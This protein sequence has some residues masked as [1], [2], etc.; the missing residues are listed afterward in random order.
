MNLPDISTPARPS[1]YAI[2]QR[3]ECPRKGWLIA[4]NTSPPSLPLLARFQDGHLV[5]DAGVEQL[6]NGTHITF[7]GEAGVAATKHALTHEKEHLFQPILEFDGVRFRPD[8]YHVGQAELVDIK[9]TKSV[10]ENH[11]HE[12][13]IYTAAA[14]E[15]GIDVQR[16][17]VMHLNPNHRKGG[18][19][20]KL[21]KQDVTEEVNALYDALDLSSEIAQLRHPDPPAAGL[22]IACKKCEFV[23]RCF[24]DPADLIN[25]IPRLT[26]P[27]LSQLTALGVH[28]LSALQNHPDALELLTP[29]Q[30]NFMQNLRA[31]DTEEVEPD[32]S[33]LAAEPW[34]QEATLAHMDFETSMKAL[35]QRTGEGPYA[36]TV[37]QFSVTVDDGQALREIGYLSDGSD[38]LEALVV[39][40]LDATAGVCPIVVHNIGFERSRINDM[41]SYLPHHASALNSLCERLV[42][43]EPVVRASLPGLGSSSLKKVAV[44]ADSE[45]T[46]DDLQIQNGEM[47]G[48]VLSLLGSPKGIEL[49]QQKTG[50]DESAARSALLAYCARDTYATAVVVRWFKRVL[51]AHIND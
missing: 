17:S 3:K 42:D 20:P 13:A 39:A 11:L 9:A 41:A 12:M 18:H 35:P 22:K 38:D 29:T 43:L 25:R 44:H 49:L 21:L 40:L 27:K 1:K 8:A 28:T 2:V 26:K 45:F 31:E 34:L 7:R 10:K 24:S 47:A 23:D 6:G 19:L 15:N 51:A 46:Y 37:M 16:I 30:Q 32:A 5:E 33:A 48:A 4:H 50:M 36:H 14:K